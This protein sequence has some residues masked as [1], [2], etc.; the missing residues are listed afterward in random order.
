M[1]QWPCSA[2]WLNLSSGEPVD[3]LRSRRFATE[4][5]YVT[6]P[7]NCITITL[8]LLTDQRTGTT[9]LVRAPNGIEYIK[10][11]DISRFRAVKFEVGVNLVTLVPIDDDRPGR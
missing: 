8:D 11:R 10:K 3:D 9:S 1:R 7:R 6:H 4:T 5:K 2:R